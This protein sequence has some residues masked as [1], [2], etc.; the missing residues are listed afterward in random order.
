VIRRAALAVA[1]AA[2]A[3]ATAVV[4]AAD[5]KRVRVFAVGPKLDLAWIDTRAHFHDKL[6]AVA[7]RSLRTPAA[8]LVQQHA[9]DVASHLLGPTDRTRAAQT[10]RDLVALPDQLG[11]FAIFTG[12]RAAGARSS[13][14]LGAALAALRGAYSSEL[15]YYA[16]RF[17]QLASRNPPGRLLAL[18]A[19]DTFGRVA[20]E[21]FAELADHL[22]SYL[23]AGVT[24]AR[25]WRI[26]CNSKATFTARP[27]GVGCDEENPLKVVRLRSRDE[28]TSDYAYEAVTGDPVSMA[29]VF[30][31]YGSLVAKQV[32]ASPAL[33]ELRGGLDLLPGALSGL[34]AVETP[35]GT[36]GI[37]A[38]RDVLAPAAVRLLEQRH[39]ELLI[40]PQFAA[41]DL[42]RVPGFWAPDGLKAGGHSA[43]LR[44][45]S[46]AGM[47]MPSLVG[48]VFDLAADAQQHIVFKPRSATRAPSGAL[49]GQARAPGFASV[50][51]YV[52]RDPL[53]GERSL[54][55]RRRRLASAAAKLTP[56][57][58]GTPCPVAAQAG[59]CVNGQVEGVLFGDLQVQQP[60]PLRR[61]R[62]QRR[63]PRSP[64]TLNRPI[65]PS[66]FPQRNVALAARGRRVWAALEER[67][68]DRDQIVLVRSSDDGT[69]WSRPVRP[70]GR[71]AG[72]ATEWWPSVAVGPDGRV[73]IAWQ[74]DSTGTPRVYVSSSGDRGSSFGEPLAVD[75]SA[76]GSAQMKPS[77][78]AGE[79]GRAVV[80]WVDERSRQPGEPALPQAGIWAARVSVGGAEGAVRLDQRRSDSTLA[81]D[82]AWAPSVSARGPNLLVSYADSGTGDWRIWSRASSDGGATWEPEQQVSAAPPATAPPENEFVGDAPASALTAR[83]PLVAFTGLHKRDSSRRAHELYDTVVT[84]PGAR[85]LQADGHGSAQLS[86][87]SPAITAIPGGGAVVAWQDHGRGPADIRASRVTPQAGS[88]SGTVRVDDTGDAGWNQWRP[89]LART[90]LRVVAAWED[91]RDGPAQIYSARARWSRIR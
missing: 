43:V 70:T 34:G 63:A 46:F 45:P 50:A 71:T 59:A 91:E 2:A 1:A 57:G 81:P 44:G 24:M 72:A 52:V 40:Q 30:D 17:P 89:A 26:V 35:V 6:F 25:S 66:R 58:G 87:F 9:D 48:T 61:Q 21:T 37:A 56:A 8:P 15:G 85:N 84:V 75:A 32:K 20:V 79:R 55:A 18:A 68:E 76:P 83:G 31:P 53:P 65:A 11:L 90:S 51:P 12:A 41:N 82:N 62:A 29:L 67:R 88:R 42:P 14:S 73:W 4:P 23:V 49:I 78:A 22:D 77:I 60:R 74:D 86:T 33:F 36:L 10:A 3:V 47:A 38:G 19:T 69:N 13:S 80:A 39:V 64:F 7:D 54:A 28:P 5:A 27:G 16:Q